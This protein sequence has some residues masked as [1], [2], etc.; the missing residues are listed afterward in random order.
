MSL[1]KKNNPAN[2]RVVLF[3]IVER[4]AIYMDNILFLN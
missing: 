4:I 1:L 3:F 2:C